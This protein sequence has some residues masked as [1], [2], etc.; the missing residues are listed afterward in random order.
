MYVRHTCLLLKL[1]DGEWMAEGQ[2]GGEGEEK[3]TEH[4]TEHILHRPAKSFTH[5]EWTMISVI[6][7][8][9]EKLKESV[10]PHLQINANRTDNKLLP[11]IFTS[12]PAVSYSGIL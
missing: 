4:Y 10:G 5:R 1:M 3:P 6:G 12:Q 7:V 2:G 8:G 11:C 9:V